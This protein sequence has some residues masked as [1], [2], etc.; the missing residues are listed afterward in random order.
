MLGFQRGSVLRR[1]RR[2][3]P[4][5]PSPTP[6]SVIVVGSGTA[7]APVNEN[8][9]SKVGAG[10]R[11]FGRDA[12]ANIRASI[13]RPNRPDLRF[14]D[15]RS[16]MSAEVG[17]LPRQFL[18]RGLRRQGERRE[19]DCARLL[20]ARAVQGFDTA[21]GANANANGGDAFAAGVG[22]QATAV[23]ATA[24]GYSA[25][26]SGINSTAFGAGALT[27][28]YGGS[29]AIGA[30]ATN[31]A[32]DQLALGA[33]GST[34]YAPGIASAASLAAQSGQT[35]FA[36]TDSAGHL[37]ASSYG[38]QDIGSLYAANQRPGGAPLS[39]KVA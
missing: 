18:R 34:I 3:A 31:T 16:P 17:T 25:T 4:S 22:A 28:R 7:A 5:P 33:A 29:T 21:I 37:A 36:T 30:G 27:G 10:V 24:V 39:L 8:A 23:G 6:K 14:Q 15:Y 11:T 20:G 13:S 1:L 38:P 12:F 32:A 2:K 19:R 35:Y 9:A 26:A